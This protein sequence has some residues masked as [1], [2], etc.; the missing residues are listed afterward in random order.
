MTL[1]ARQPTAQEAVARKI[2]VLIV[3]DSAVIRGLLTRWL[4]SE[5]DVEIAGI[6]VNGREGVRLAG[7][8][9]PDVVVLDIE[10]PIMDGLT[11]L[12]GILK[13]APGSRVIMASNLTQRGG[14]VTIRALAAGASDYLAKP[15]ANNVAAAADYKKE[16]LLKVRML[17]SRARRVSP[18]TPVGVATGSTQKWTEV[19]SGQGALRPVSMQARPK[20]IFIGSSTGGPEAL[21]VVVAGLVGKIDVPVLIAQHMPALFTK[22]LAEHLCKLTGA[23]VIEAEHGMIAKAGHFYIAPGNF[24]MMVG[25]SAETIRIELNDDA[26]ENFCRPAV[27]PLFRSAAAALGN[28]ALAVVLTGMGSDGRE[29]GKAMVAKGCSL[30]AQD[31]ETSVVWGMPGAVV[32]AGLASSSKPLNDIASAILS[33]MRGVSP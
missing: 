29:G 17:G 5:P 12:P 20:A 2:R 3:E 30:I 1:G 32:R 11:A 25:Y 6:A 15:S 26:Q 7:E 18:P 27:D 24:H 10:M 19:S 8:S 33:V 13:S 21:K 28:R 23:K 31:E 14:E 4:G 22:I 16:L 9:N